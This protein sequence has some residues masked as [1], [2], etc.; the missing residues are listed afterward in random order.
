MLLGGPAAGRRFAALVLTLAAAA[1]AC[2]LLCS[3]G[4][5]YLPGCC[6]PNSGASMATRSRSE[7]TK[8]LSIEGKLP[9]GY[10]IVCNRRGD[11]FSFLVRNLG[12]SVECP[13]CG[14]TVE[15]TDL[16]LQY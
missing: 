5:S 8:H 11:E 10:V 12:L 2:W 7:M 3:A 13:H 15:S 14:T 9:E 1:F 16:A 6:V 4:T